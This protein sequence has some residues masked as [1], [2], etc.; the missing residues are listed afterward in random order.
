MNVILVDYNNKE[1]GIADKTEAHKCGLLHKAF[2]VFLLNDRNELLLQKRQVNKY[3]SGGLWTNTCCSH[4]Y[5]GCDENNVI[6]QQLNFEMG[7]K[8]YVERIFDFYYYTSFQNGLFEHEYDTVYL[9]YFN[10]NPY[11]NKDEVSDYKWI[12]LN[13]IKQ[14][15]ALHPNDYTYWFKS[16]FL[17]FYDFVII[18]KR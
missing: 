13:L 18:L 3:H 16:I 11:I 10:G 9:G 15:I 14:D 6:I 7:I 8:C 12:D 17:P 5:P 1:I 2:S 4:Q